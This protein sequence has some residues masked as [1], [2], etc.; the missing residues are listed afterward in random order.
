FGFLALLTTILPAAE[1]I[2]NVSYIILRRSPRKNLLFMGKVKLSRSAELSFLS[3]V[4]LTYV[5]PVNEVVRGKITDASG[6]IIRKGDILAKASDTKE[7]IIV[8]ICTQK[9]KKTKLSLKDANL[10]LKRIEKLYKRHVFS[11]RQHEE[12]ENEYLQAASDYDVCRLE[13]L[14]AKSNLDKKILRAPFSGIVE[15]VLAEEGSSLC[16]DKSVL[17]LSVFDPMCITVQLHDVLTDLLCVN[18]Q[19]LVYP[20]GFTKASSAW[21]KT[22]EIFTDY[23]ELSV[24]NSLVPK[25]KLTPEQEKLP[26]IYTRLRTIKDPETPEIPMWAPTQSLRKDSKGSFVWT[27]IVNNSAKPDFHKATN[28]IVKKIRVKTKNMFMQKHSAQYQALENP[29]NLKDSQIVLIS[30]SGNLLDG[31]KAIMQDSSWLFQP[32]EQVWVS[33]PQLSEHIYT[34]PQDALRV[35]KGRT[36]I[37][38]INKDSKAFPIEIFVYNKSNRIAEIIGKNLKPGMK[39]VCNKSNGLLYFG[40]KV[41]LSRR[42]DF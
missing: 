27:I 22:Q 33:I 15:K 29:G 36:F 38:V 6:K 17:V 12:A 24:K 40:K 3:D 39:I 8:N 26:K 5:A 25:R 37:C 2:N 10:N 1:H 32:T 23:I 16:D 19:F 30:T 9:V 21:L 34:V 20:T 41:K 28:I 42:I 35:F 18:D 11:E 7:R 4:Q 13:L 31:G 14:D